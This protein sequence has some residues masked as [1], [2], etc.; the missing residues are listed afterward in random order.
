VTSRHRYQQR[1]AYVWN[2][3]ADTAIL[4]D[5]AG[6]NVDSCRWTRTGTG[7]ISC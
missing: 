6:R 5:A 7:K 4:R 1:A 3:D 2:N